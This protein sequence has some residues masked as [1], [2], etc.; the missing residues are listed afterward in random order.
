MPFPV[1]M[2]VLNRGQEKFNLYCTPCH[3][4]VGNG[5]GMI[6]QRGYKPA[7]NF[8]DQVHLA[9]PLSHYFYV[10]THGY[11]AMP[12]YAAQLNPADRWAVA[13]YIRVLQLSQDAPL[14]DVPAGVTVKSLKEV[15]TEEGLPASYAEPWSLPTTAVWGVKLAPQEGTPAMAPAAQ[16]L[17]PITIPTSKTAKGAAK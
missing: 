13:A 17:K 15:A 6:V 11:G 3:S 8:H 1:T 12:D 16:G 14:K 10:M 4:R 2:T 9:Q 5:L 7:A